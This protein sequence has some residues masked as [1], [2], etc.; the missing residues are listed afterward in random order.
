M[1]EDIFKDL[2]ECRCEDMYSIEPHGK[3]YAIYF[4]RCPHKHGYNLAHLTE[5]SRE[6]M[7]QFI[8]FALNNHK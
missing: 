4:G 8:E 2:M 1:K 6:D 5:I 7:I 3:G